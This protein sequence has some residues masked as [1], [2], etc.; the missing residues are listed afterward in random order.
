MITC[1]NASRANIVIA[2]YVLIFWCKYIAFRRWGK[3]RHVVH[4]QLAAPSFHRGC[5]RFQRVYSHRCQEL[6]KRVSI[7]K[8]DALNRH[9]SLRTTHRIRIHYESDPEDR[10][11]MKLE[12]EPLSV[13]SPSAANLEEAPD[14]PVPSHWLQQSSYVQHRWWSFADNPAPIV[15]VCRLLRRGNRS[16]I[17]PMTY[18]MMR[19]QSKLLATGSD[20]CT[21]AEAS[22][23]VRCRRE[24]H[25]LN[26]KR[27]RI[28]WAMDQTSSTQSAE[29]SC[30]WCTL[31]QFR[32][33]DTATTFCCAI[34][35][36]TVAVS[37]SNR[38]C[39]ATQRFC[40][41][42][43][44]HRIQIRQTCCYLNKCFQRGVFAHD[45]I[46]KFIFQSFVFSLTWYH[47]P[48]VLP[49]AKR[50]TE[51]NTCIWQPVLI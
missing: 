33:C 40:S 46:D 9:Y 36:A 16:R 3:Y 19:N 44:V 26:T 6:F 1:R 38:I 29:C 37:L 17:G 43:H 50:Y 42:D 5:C 47:R 51:N 20:L 24:Y 10:C 48:F 21:P 32:F 49:S 25:R 18:W 35:N 41:F 31:W 2:I 34:R 22:V 45:I 27:L 15:A 12:C 30:T 8:S 28:G 4:Y 23:N 13:L 11:R 7:E 39:R 14:L